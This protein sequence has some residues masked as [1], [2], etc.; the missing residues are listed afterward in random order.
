MIQGGKSSQ[1]S[2]QKTLSKQVELVHNWR[3]FTDVTLVCG[4]EQSEAHKIR[5]DKWG[6]ARSLLRHLSVNMTV[7]P[8]SDTSDIDVINSYNEEEDIENTED[9][10]ERNNKEEKS[11]DHREYKENLWP[12]PPDEPKGYTF[13]GKTKLLAF[14]TAKTKASLKKGYCIYKCTATLNFL[15]RKQID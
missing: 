4:D 11:N 2:S 15:E 10:F 7:P 6:I 12:A 1:S 14:A 5:K 9:T 3:E 8:V 13:K